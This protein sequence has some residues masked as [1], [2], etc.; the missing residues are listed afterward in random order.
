MKEDATATTTPTLRPTTDL[1]L[2]AFLLARGHPIRA[3]H[4]GPRTEFVFEAP[5]S[6]VLLFYS[7]DCL[8]HARKLLDALHTMQGLLKAHGVRR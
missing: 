1:Y 7:D 4:P 8:I 2:S 3:V 6:E 5:D